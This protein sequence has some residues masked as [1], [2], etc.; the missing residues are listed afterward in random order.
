MFLNRC[1]RFSAVGL[2]PVAMSVKA[3]CVLFIGANI[4]VC[5]CSINYLS[6]MISTLV[7]LWS[8]WFGKSST[9][10]KLEDSKT[11]RRRLY[12]Q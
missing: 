6:D 9:K 11:L 5:Q 3:A 7:K 4:S 1:L 2:T 8:L 12:L 10:P